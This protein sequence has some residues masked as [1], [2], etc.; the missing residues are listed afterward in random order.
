M[1]IRRSGL[2]L[3]IFPEFAGEDDRTKPQL[4]V[5]GGLDE[6]FNQA[7]NS[8]EMLGPEAATEKATAADA[9]E[10]EMGLLTVARRGYCSVAIA[11]VLGKL[12]K[13]EPKEEKR[14][15]ERRRG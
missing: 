10:F 3:S 4:F 12:G 8:T 15:W 13:P 6:T 11:T 5:V 9:A 1:C 2:A 7:Q 14:T